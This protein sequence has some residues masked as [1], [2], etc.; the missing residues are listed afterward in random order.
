M[1]D[2]KTSTRRENMEGQTGKRGDM[3]C[4]EGKEDAFLVNEKS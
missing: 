2:R 4:E 3:A 1:R